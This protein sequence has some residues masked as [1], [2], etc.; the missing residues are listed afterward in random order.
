MKDLDQELDNLLTRGRLPLIELH[1][2]L[3]KQF[4]KQRLTK[5]KQLVF[6]LPKKINFVLWPWMI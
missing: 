4:S 1:P 6:R 3:P 5:L 2:M